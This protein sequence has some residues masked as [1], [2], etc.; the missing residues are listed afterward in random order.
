[1]IDA[2]KTVDEVDLYGTVVD[3]SVSVVRVSET[4]GEAK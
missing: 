1:M 4:T 3:A 2:R